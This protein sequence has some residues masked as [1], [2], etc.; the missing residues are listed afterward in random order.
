M[1]VL[2]NAD[3]DG[4]WFEV[5]VISGSEAAFT[6]KLADNI[7]EV[8]PWNSGHNQESG[9]VRDETFPYMQANDGLTYARSNVKE[10][11]KVV[12]KL[13]AFSFTSVSV[14]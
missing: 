7:Q 4:K 12:T 10:V 11:N 6:V 9:G 14:H 3:R 5:A 8:V 2:Q 1:Q 13:L